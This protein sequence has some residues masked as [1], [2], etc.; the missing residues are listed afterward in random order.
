VESVKRGETAEFTINKCYLDGSLPDKEGMEQFETLL[1]DLFPEWDLN[2]DL[3]AHLVLEKLV[4]VE[5]W[6]KNGSTLVKMI[7]KG[8]KG[9]S[10][11]ADTTV[12]SK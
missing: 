10:P 1:P 11:Y 7:R 5:D 8:G 4:K 3:Y 6:Y 9:R 2:K 12:K